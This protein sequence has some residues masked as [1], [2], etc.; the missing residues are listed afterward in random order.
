L[1]GKILSSL[2]SPALLLPD[3]HIHRFLLLLALLTA[4]FGCGAPAV[5]QVDFQLNDTRAL[6]SAP[7]NR[8]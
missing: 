2:H 6:A 7:I 3:S 4:L 5:E 1:S 8:C